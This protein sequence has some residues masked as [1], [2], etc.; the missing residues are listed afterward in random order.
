M[1]AWHV[2]L[3]H[4]Q[5]LEQQGFLWQVVMALYI[6]PCVLF[7]WLSWTGTDYMCNVTTGQCAT[8]PIPQDK[9]GEYTRNRNLGLCNLNCIL[10]ALNSF[11]NDWGGFLQT[12]TEAGI[13]PVVNPP[14]KDLPYVHTYCSIT[15]N[16][17]HQ[18][19]QGILK[20]LINWVSQAL[21]PLKIDVQCHQLPP[22]HNIQ[23]FAKGI[24]SLPE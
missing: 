6:T 7:W 8:C 11:D 21:S 4:L 22:N 2:F 9:M 18:L 10:E 20:H 24:T 17:L 12:C 19:Y 15:P 23:H 5:R 1:P 16:I 14:Q 13:K 3:H